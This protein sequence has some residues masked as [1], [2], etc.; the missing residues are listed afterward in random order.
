MVRITYDI[1][2][3]CKSELA[4]LLPHP[5]QLDGINVL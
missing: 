2:S 1:F 5:L 3:L 4:I